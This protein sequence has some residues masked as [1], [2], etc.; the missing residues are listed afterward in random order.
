MAHRA[1]PSR[2]RALR[3]LD[4]HHHVATSPRL[5]PQQASAREA[6]LAA[7]KA[8]DPIT[9]ALRSFRSPTLEGWRQ[10]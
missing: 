5:N 6:L 7:S 3:Q 4:R 10:T 1:Y 9:K 2:Q 8:L